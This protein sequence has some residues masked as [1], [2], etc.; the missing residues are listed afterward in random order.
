MDVKH[1]VGVL[2]AVAGSLALASCSGETRPATEVTNQSARLNAYGTAD[3][4]PA[5]S[6]FRLES[7]ASGPG[8]YFAE[9]SWPAGASGPLSE[10]V[11]GLFAGRTYTFRICGG[12]VGKEAVC[13]APR[14]FTTST[15]ATQDM[16]RAVWVLGKDSN[17]GV[18]ASS[19]PTGQSPTGSVSGSSFAGRVVCLAVNG[20]RAAIGAVD[21]NNGAAVLTF[22]DGGSSAPDT[23]YQRSVS[24]EGA[25]ACATASFADQFVPTSWPERRDA[26]IVQDAR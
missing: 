15:P 16:V 21:S 14:T 25:S 11:E 4:G 3:N 10:R 9:R 6:Y 8:G 12:D 5:F 2:G 7:A 13:A 26:I 1:A 19:G 18:E 23:M 20:S 17:G 22:V 24:T